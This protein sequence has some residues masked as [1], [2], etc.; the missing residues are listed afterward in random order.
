M[1]QVHFLNLYFH[2]LINLLIINSLTPHFPVFQF[3]KFYFLLIFLLN[4]FHSDQSYLIQYFQLIF[5]SLFII[6][7]QNKVSTNLFHLLT[8]LFII[9][10]FILIFIITQFIRFKFILIFIF[11]CF[12]EEL[13]YDLQFFQPILN[14]FILIKYLIQFLK[15]SFHF[16]II[17]FII[18]NFSIFILNFKFFSF[19]L[20]LPFIIYKFII[21]NFLSL[22]IIQF[23]IY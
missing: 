23:V 7:F 10:N 19:N 21:L 8:I 14:L 9:S 22:L 5:Y 16:Q 2:F 11:H 1:I 4:A 3:T 17:Q 13:F 6:K 20:F 12:L 18:K 15:N